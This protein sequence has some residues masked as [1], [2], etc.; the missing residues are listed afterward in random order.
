VFLACLKKDGQGM[1]TQDNQ[2]VLPP[3]DNTTKVTPNVSTSSPSVTYED[4]SSMFVDHEFIIFSCCSCESMCIK[5]VGYSCSFRNVNSSY[6]CVSHVNQC[7][8][9]S[10]ATHVPLE[11][12]PI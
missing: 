9:N 5:C 2:V 12:S 4:A 1:V 3:I 7:A 10:S 11:K 8:S 6:S